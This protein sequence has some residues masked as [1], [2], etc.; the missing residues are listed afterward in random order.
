MCI[1]DSLHTEED[2]ADGTAGEGPRVKC[3]ADD[4][5]QHRREA[6]VVDDLSLIHISVALVIYLVVYSTT[7][8]PVHLRRKALRPDLSLEGR[9]YEMCIR[10]RP[11][12][13]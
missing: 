4:G 7:E 8:S 5:G 1:R 11:I 3:T 6:P 12:I 10:D 2:A 9:L 13:S